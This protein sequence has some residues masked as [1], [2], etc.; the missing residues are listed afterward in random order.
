MM[1]QHL[2][3]VTALFSLETHRKLKLHAFNTDR[4]LIQIIDEAVR[5]WLDKHG[6]DSA[7]S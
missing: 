5:D 7:R 6:P 1:V 4:T 2:K 3:R